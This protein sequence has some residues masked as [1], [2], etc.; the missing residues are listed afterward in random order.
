M[1]IRIFTWQVH[2]L[3]FMSIVKPAGEHKIQKSK[4]V[5]AALVRAIY[6]YIPGRLGKV[7]KTLLAITFRQ[8]KR[9]IGS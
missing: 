8:P 6:N 9:S 4:V 5:T 3:T 7:E 2:F 1:Q